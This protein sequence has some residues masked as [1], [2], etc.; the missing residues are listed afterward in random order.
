MAKP[1][2]LTKWNQVYEMSGKEACWIIVN[3]REVDSAPR[4]AELLP[5]FNEVQQLLIT[6]YKRGLFNELRFHIYWD[7]E[8]SIEFR[9]EINAMNDVAQRLNECKCPG[10]RSESVVED[11]TY[12]Y[13]TWCAGEIENVPELLGQIKTRLEIKDL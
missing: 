13:Y 8:G 5:L 6:E 10:S 12:I 4:V 1:F 3:K 11:R 9:F 2:D 7:D